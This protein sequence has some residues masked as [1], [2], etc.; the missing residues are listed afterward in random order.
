MDLTVQNWR[1]S[2]NSIHGPKEEEQGSSKQIWALMHPENT[3]FFSL[4]ISILITYFQ[5]SE[6]L[7]FIQFLTKPSKSNNY[8]LSN[9]FRNSNLHST[10]TQ[11]LTSWQFC[12]SFRVCLLGSL[13][14]FLGFMRWWWVLLAAIGILSLLRLTEFSLLS[15]STSDIIKEDIETT[16]I[17]S[18]IVLPDTTTSNDIELESK[19]LPISDDNPPNYNGSLFHIVILV[20]DR[21]NTFRQSMQRVMS[22]TPIRGAGMTV[23]QHKTNP[24]IREIIESYNLPRIETL[25]RHVSDIYVWMLKE[26]FTR[27]PEVQYLIILEDDL[28]ISTDFFDYCRQ[29]APLFDEDPTIFSIRGWTD[30]GFPFTTDMRKMDGIYRSEIF[31]GL[32]WMISRRIWEQYIAPRKPPFKIKY[33]AW[34]IWFQGVAISN[35]LSHIYPEVPRIYHYFDNQ[36]GLTTTP[37]IQFLFYE[38]MFLHTEPIVDLGDIRR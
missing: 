18:A 16:D 14:N 2:M 35:N 7:Q 21:V 3:L 5:F 20:K 25:L 8:L 26:I 36:K 1:N 13:T 24:K 12:R 28:F 34:D 4:T 9:L 22:A 33:C 17:P 37:K 23:I 32:G 10:T 19:Y 29:L 30:H 31:T 11:I 38:N 27:H 15:G 6:F